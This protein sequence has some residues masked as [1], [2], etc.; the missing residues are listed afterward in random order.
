MKKPFRRWSGGRGICVDII[1]HDI[2][3]AHTVKENEIVSIRAAHSTKVT[4]SAFH[5]QL[6]PFHINSCR[7]SIHS[8]QQLSPTIAQ[9]CKA[10]SS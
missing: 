7:H 1:W 5:K 2:G 6:S 10:S 8:Y 4:L 3:V 9:T